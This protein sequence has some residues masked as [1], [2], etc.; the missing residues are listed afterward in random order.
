MLEQYINKVPK[1]I[2]P[3]L[4]EF[5]LG[6]Y[7][8]YFGISIAIAIVL[9]IFSDQSLVLDL[10]GWIL[11]VFII[12]TTITRCKIFTQEEII[13]WLPLTIF[14]YLVANYV[15]EVDCH[16]EWDYLYSLREIINFILE[17]SFVPVFCSWYVFDPVL[18]IHKPK[19][20]E[21][22]GYFIDR[23]PYFTGYGLA[24]GLIKINYPYRY[25]ILIIIA[26]I[27]M[28]GS[29]IA[30]SRRKCPDWALRIPYRRYTQDIDPVNIISDNIN[31]I[32]R[33]SSLIKVK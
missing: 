31:Q 16:F 6:I 29:D 19:F 15:L 2:R 20:S 18:I 5:I 25:D 24:M 10:K 33:K 14:S 7:D 22:M 8:S 28:I 21:R 23:Y 17:I 27:M 1:G 9:L 12:I 13:N 32:S 3:Y 11:E 4:R 26:I 30:N